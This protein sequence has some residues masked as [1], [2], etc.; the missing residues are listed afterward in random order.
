[1]SFTAFQ[2]MKYC[3]VQTSLK[4]S[5]PEMS[6]KNV[7]YSISHDEECDSRPK[8]RDSNFM[9]IDQISIVVTKEDKEENKR[10]A[11]MQKQGRKTKKKHWIMLQV[12]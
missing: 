4:F 6:I 8:S 2:N 11:E 7:T 9:S 3:F 12:Q 5:N 1:M 10:A